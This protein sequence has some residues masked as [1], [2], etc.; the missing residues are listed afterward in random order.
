MVA[1]APFRGFL[2][3]PSRA[4]ASHAPVWREPMI[5]GGREAARA[6]SQLLANGNLKRDERPAVYRYHQVFQSPEL[7]DQRVVRRGIITAVRLHPFED[8][9]IQTHEPA[10]PRLEAEYLARMEAS[11]A[12]TAPIFALYS[13]PSGETD[14]L[15]APVEHRGPLVECSTADGTRHRVWRADNREIIGKLVRLMAPQKLYI[16]EG[17]DRYA[18]MLAF[19]DQRRDAAGGLLSQGSAAQFGTMFLANVDDPG[20]VVL[21][22]HRVIHG[23]EGFVP[24]EMLEAATDYFDIETVE[25][26][27]LEAPRLRAAIHEASLE[28]PSF[29]AVWPFNDDAALLS[30]KH[31]T[32]IEDLE[33]AGLVG[34]PALIHLDVSLLN[35][36]VLDN[37]LGLDPAAQKH[38]RYVEDS[39]IALEL[40]LEC[41]GEVA[42]IMSPARVDQIKAVADAHEIL[43]AR[44]ASFHPAIA[45]GLVLN[46]IDADEE[47]G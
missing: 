11:G 27:A 37:I 38:I 41:K 6:L 30:L 32:A 1:I 36:L 42:F 15:F 40:M 39:R 16:A 9:V 2:Q 13:D 25:R 29:A 22:I 31:G 24:E 46:S 26:G 8:G 47:I 14:R 19:R 34:H 20:L 10:D 17:R 12:H 5:G 35:G 18:A 28:R 23:L 4:S 43:P 33:Q 44:A 45:S 21:P 3:G 7:G